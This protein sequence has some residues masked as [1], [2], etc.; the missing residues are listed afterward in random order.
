MIFNQVCECNSTHIKYIS[1][2]TAFKRGDK[3]S[4]TAPMVHSVPLLWLG[5]VPI[6][7]EV[8]V[9]QHQVQPCI[10]RMMW[11]VDVPL[12]TDSTG[13]IFIADSTGF[14]IRQIDGKTGII[15]TVAGHGT[16]G[17]SG[18]GGQATSATFKGPMGLEIDTVSDIQGL[19]TG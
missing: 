12:A 5:M 16:Y 19:L 2:N 13:N 15:Q 4:P 17:Y 14:T 7:K 11:Q 9:Y 18:D 1:K 10:T 3:F 8:M 6:L